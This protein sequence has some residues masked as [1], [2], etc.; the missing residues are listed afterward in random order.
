MLRA[1]GCKAGMKQRDSRPLKEPAGLA[2]VQDEQ[3]PATSHVFP[4]KLA[5]I[6]KVRCVFTAWQ[7]LLVNKTQATLL[8]IIS[9][10]SGL[11]AR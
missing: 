5:G 4:E 3:P 11:F 8:R 9:H 6:E 1:M 10:S 2:G 7:M